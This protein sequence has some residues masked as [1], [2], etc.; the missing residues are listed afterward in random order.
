MKARFAD[1]AYYFA[2]L[3]ES[4][5]HHALAVRL[6]RERHRLVT[7]RWVLAEVADGLSGVERRAQF[8]ALLKVLRGSRVVEIL[9]GSDD[10]FDRG[11]TLYAQRPDKAWSLTDCISFVAMENRAIREALTPD[12]H[13]EQAGFVALPK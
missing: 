12:H 9:H 6:S 1:A 13:F 11:A 10:L 3:S 2:L 5:E 8:V 7:T 4:D